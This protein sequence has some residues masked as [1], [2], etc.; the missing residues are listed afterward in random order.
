[1]NDEQKRKIMIEK[2][3]RELPPFFTRRVAE[4]VLGGA[5]KASTLANLDSQGLGPGGVNTGK[6]VLYE[7]DGFVDWFF[8]RRRKSLLGETSTKA[9]I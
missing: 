5:L 4:K 7:R 2:L 1:M 6:T 9:A 8:N 3:T